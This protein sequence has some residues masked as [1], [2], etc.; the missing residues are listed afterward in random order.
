MV[1]RRD[2]G[3]EF[4]VV[5]AEVA[6]KIYAKMEEQERERENYHPNRIPNGI[7]SFFSFNCCALI[8]KNFN[9]IQKIVEVSRKH[10]IVT[11]M[12]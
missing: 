4:S 1:H 5:P 8:P 11:S 3:F 9:G 6:K 2:D 12:F 10:N 7:N